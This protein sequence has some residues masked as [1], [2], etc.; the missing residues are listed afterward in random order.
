MSYST[1]YSMGLNAP[2]E[3]RPQGS[4]GSY[5]SSFSDRQEYNQRERDLLRELRDMSESGT[6]NGPSRAYSAVAKLNSYSTS[7]GASREVLELFP[8]PP[9]RY[10]AP[11]DRPTYKGDMCIPKKDALL[12]E[13]IMSD[14]ATL[15]AQLDVTK[16]A[17]VGKFP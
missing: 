4:S 3:R 7:E 9:K 11:Q 8:P 15:K 1:S 6:G 10:C 13:M 5:E 14:K 12:V 2:Y 17:I 16:Q